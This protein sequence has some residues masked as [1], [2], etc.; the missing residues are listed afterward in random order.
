MSAPPT[1]GYRILVYGR[2][3]T[4]LDTRRLVLAS[5]GFR[6]N[7]VSDLQQFQRSVEQARP[8]YELF[9]LCH[10]VPP[11]ELEIIRALAAGLGTG[12]YYLEK[13]EAPARLIHN[14][15]EMVAP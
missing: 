2:D 8:P 13:M 5:S 1:N 12:L 4:L 11:A 3:S 6:V 10:T 9:I 15:S 7:T 14:A